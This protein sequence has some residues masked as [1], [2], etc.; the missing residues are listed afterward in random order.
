[1]AVERAVDKGLTTEGGQKASGKAAGRLRL[2]E[3]MAYGVTA[4]LSAALAFVR[5]PLYTYWFEPA[6]YG[7]FTLVSTG[8]G[9]LSSIVLA[10]FSNVLYRRYDAERRVGRLDTFLST[11]TVGTVGSLVLVG[12]AAWAAG[13]WLRLQ[14]SAA[15][16]WL[17]VLTSILTFQSLV[18]QVNRM[19]HQVAAFVIGKLVDPVWQLGAP[20]LFLALGL[21]GFPAL[22]GTAVTAAAGSLL[23]AAAWARPAIAGI[24]V[25]KTDRTVFR[26]ALAYGLPLIPL[27]LTGWVIASSNRYVIQ[28]FLGSE[29]TGVFSMGYSLASG[30][31][32][33]LSGVIVMTVGP[34]V[35]E[36]LNI[37]GSVEALALVRR[38]SSLF[39]ALGLPSAIGLGLLGDRIVS[40]LFS[41]A[42]KGATVVILPTALGAVFSGLYSFLVKPWELHEATRVVPLYVGAGALVNLASNILLVPRLGIEGAAWGSLLA[43]GVVAVLMVSDAWRRYATWLL[44]DWKDTLSVAGASLVMAIAVMMLRAAVGHGAGAL[45]G[46]MG[47]GA[48]VYLVSLLVIGFALKSGL[49]GALR[50][51][52]VQPIRRFLARALPNNAGRPA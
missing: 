38:A 40:I 9:L 22:A 6:T 10:V 31:I 49:L 30:P 14:G 24:D 51:T 32:G 45:L 5:A 3:G 26:V 39:L 2:S 47:A 19:E 29:A 17:I 37:R 28:Y 12:L 33:L 21:S 52:A 23:V 42:Y 4:I 20:L 13:E 36:R 25:G 18:S 48:T 11:L 44:P 34:V 1:M 41:T 7:D 50:A 16:A 43:Y 35:W 27:A 8:A 15:I 46:V